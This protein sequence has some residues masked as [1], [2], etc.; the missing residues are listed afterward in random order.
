MS[1]FCSCLRPYHK[2]LL[3]IR[4]F[5][6][7]VFPEDEFKPMETDKIDSSKIF[8]I[9]YSINILPSFCSHIKCSGN[10][11]KR[12]YVNSDVDFMFILGKSNE[13]GIFKHESV[14][15][16][17]EFKWREQARK[18]FV[19]NSFIHF[20]YIGILIIYTE[21][22]Y[23]HL[24]LYD[25]KTGEIGENH[26]YPLILLAGMTIPFIYEVISFYMM[27]PKRYFTI[28][29]NYLDLTYIF[30]GV[31]T[32]LWHYNKSYADQVGE[33]LFLILIGMNIARTFK[34]LRIFTSFSPIV[35][36]LTNVIYDLR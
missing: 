10:L 13:L 23:I 32:T 17:N 34:Y 4:H 8:K 19:F 20:C 25:Q 21:A 7:E 1:I 11:S 33:I 5:Y 30:F 26:F 31:L 12:K 16:L 28:I 24:H 27:G 18:N 36:M 22:I 35:T 14:I 6:K 15:T 2:S 9:K 29:E 3:K